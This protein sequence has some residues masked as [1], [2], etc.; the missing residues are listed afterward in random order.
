[1]D[2]FLILLVVAA[3]VAVLV[4]LAR[5]LFRRVTVFEYEA[6]VRYDDGRLRGV[7]GPGSYWIAPAR[8]RLEKLD[9]R[10]TTIHV[11][12]QEIITD[13]GVSLRASV[14][15]EYRITDPAVATHSTDSFVAAL[16]VALQL[17]LREIV[18]GTP[19]DDLL[20]HRNEIGA[21]L[22]ELASPRAAEL[23]LELKSAEVKDLMFPGE[24]RKTFAQVVSARKEGEAA[25]ERARGETAALRNLANAARMMEQNPTL[26]QLRLLQQLGS[27]GG[28]TIVLGL[29]SSTTPVPLRPAG[30][31]APEL[32]PQD[33]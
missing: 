30:D 28:N 31:D 4:V 33:E 7:V 15:A 27:S 24:L 13:D 21:K 14:A 9:L 23:G 12:G 29:P 6:A 18:G 8:T 25:L 17:A 32:P 11:P 22:L 3:V 10:P 26:L 20:H 1:L 2:V 5:S 16:Y 19:V